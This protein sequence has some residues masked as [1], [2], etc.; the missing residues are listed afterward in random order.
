MY[1]GAG[2]IKM[3]IKSFLI[4]MGSVDVTDKM[5]NTIYNQIKYYPETAAFFGVTVSRTF[6]L[7][8]KKKK[9]YKQLKLNENE[10]RR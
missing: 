1:T 9:K 10:R 6:K 7:P 8:R 4:E 2:G 5:V 3:Y